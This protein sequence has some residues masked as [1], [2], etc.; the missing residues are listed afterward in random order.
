MKVYADGTRFANYPC[1]DNS[2]IS[3]HKGTVNAS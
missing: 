3:Q 1:V 2:E